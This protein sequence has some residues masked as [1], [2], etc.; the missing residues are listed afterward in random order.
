METNSILALM[1]KDHERITELLDNVEKNG[2]PEIEAFY[3][4]KWYLE[5][6]IFV[7]EKAI[8][9]SYQPS[10]DSEEH[11]IFNRLSREHTALMDLLDKILKESFPKGNINFNKVKKL[12]ATHK[13]FEEK[14]VYPQLEK[15]LSKEDKQEIIEKIMDVI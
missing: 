9:I 12:L 5:K 13:K 1:I 14:E 6:H 15:K 8:F 7:E 4:F 11:K 10:D 2:H 3:K